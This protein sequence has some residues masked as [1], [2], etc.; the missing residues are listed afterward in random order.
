MSAVRTVFSRGRPVI[1]NQLRGPIRSSRMQLN[2]ISRSSS[3]HSSGISSKLFRGVNLSGKKFERDQILGA[4][5]DFK[6]LVTL[7]SGQ[8]A[9]CMLKRKVEVW[10]Q[11]GGRFDFSDEILSK[12]NFEGFNFS[13]TNF[14]GT[15]L[16]RSILR[17]T[18]LRGA[19]FK[20]AD[21][22][23]ADLVGAELGGAAINKKAIMT[24]NTGEWK[25]AVTLEE[26]LALWKERN[27]KFGF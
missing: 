3:S 12:K 22:S 1:G 23:G 7:D 5:I 11:N 14:N 24:L 9:S 21:L 19:D 18:D 4:V 10:K 25:D 2:R 27:G 16:A 20:D 6:S 8:F 17:D 13:G 26:K 15:N